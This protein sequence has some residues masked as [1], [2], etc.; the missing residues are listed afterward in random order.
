MQ[1]ILYTVTLRGK[2]K[3]NVFKMVVNIR[4]KVSPEVIDV[5]SHILMVR[6][7]VKIQMNVK[8]IVLFIIQ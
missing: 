7:L 4:S 2:M 1:L 3:N 8:E 5:L 6:S